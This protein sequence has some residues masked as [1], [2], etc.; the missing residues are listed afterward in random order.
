M[1]YAYFIIIMWATYWPCSSPVHDSPK[2][3]R[4]KEPSTSSKTV[5]NSGRQLVFDKAVYA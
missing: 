4:V 3:A 2:K 1:S 5:K